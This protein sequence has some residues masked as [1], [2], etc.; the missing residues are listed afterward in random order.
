MIP[1]CGSLLGR[2]CILYLITVGNTEGLA[3]SI[4]QNARVQVKN[5]KVIRP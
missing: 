4:N 3:V 5:D 2:K 1:L